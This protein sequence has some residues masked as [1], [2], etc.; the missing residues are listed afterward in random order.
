M[1]RKISSW[2]PKIFACGATSAENPSF[3]FPELSSRFSRT[4]FFVFQNFSLS[5]PELF[6][7]FSR[8]FSLIFQ[9]FLL[10][11]TFSVIFQNFLYFS[12]TCT[13]L[14][15]LKQLSRTF[16]KCSFQNLFQNFKGAGNFVKSPRYPRP[17]V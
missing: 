12:R 10:S 11:R 14:N 1:L 8:T 13:K 4:F 6:S 16:Q 2:I 15:Q 3:G 5:F 17:R 9:N 7:Q